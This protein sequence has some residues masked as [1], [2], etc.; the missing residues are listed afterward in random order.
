[1]KLQSLNTKNNKI[2]KSK[3]NKDI[4][5]KKIVN[6]FISE[7]KDVLQKLASR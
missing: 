4:K 2:N 5:F 6:E 1:M 7:H 3:L